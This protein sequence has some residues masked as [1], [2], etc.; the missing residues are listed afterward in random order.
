MALEEILE[1]NLNDGTVITS[2][3][4]FCFECMEQNMGYDH[5][6]SILMLPSAK[7]VT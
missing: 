6:S 5:D 1:K 4:L 3:N 7:L 2:L